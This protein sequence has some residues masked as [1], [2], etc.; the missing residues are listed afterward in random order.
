MDEP[1]KK[2]AA[3]W[4]EQLTPEQFRVTRQC[5][6]ESPFT[7]LY[8]DCHDAGTYRCVCCGSAL[9]DASA[10]FDSGSGW[11]SFFQAE[12][13][14]R[15]L[16]RRDSSH[17]MV[18]DEVCCK[19]CGAHLGHVFPDGPKPTGLRFC[20]NSAALSLDKR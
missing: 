4:R 5:G 11:P 12:Q 2:S 7:G 3:E 14:D 13:A 6:T 19:Q 1:S 20:I 18:R 10:K 15:L 8:W 17:G 16:I 9:F